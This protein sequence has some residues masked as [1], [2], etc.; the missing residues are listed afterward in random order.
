MSRTSSRTRTVLAGTLAGLLTVSG[1]AI[2]AETIVSTTTTEPSRQ[3]EVLDL[4]GA[5]LTELKLRHGIPRPFEV[6][7]TDVD[8]D[9]G[10]SFSVDATMNNLHL[11]D[12]SDWSGDHIASEHVDLS[13]STNPLAAAGLEVD[14]S[15][16]LLLSTV[17]SVSCSAVAT[18]RGLSL[19]SLTALLTDPLCS[20]LADLHGINLLSLNA[21]TN[22][23][24]A[25][26]AFDDVAIVGAILD[27]IDL[28]G[29]ALAA[30]PLVPGHGTPGS[31]D[32]P[33]CATGIGAPFCSATTPTVRQTLRGDSAGVLS[34]SLAD[35]LD[36]ALGEL[37]LVSATGAGAV[38]S[39]DDV[40]AALLASS[41]PLTDGGGNPLGSTVA[42][43]GQAL[44]SYSTANQLAIIDSLLAS[45]LAQLDLD[46]LLHLTG[47]Y[48]SY[49]AL[50]VD[51]TT[52][53]V[54][55]EYQG[56]LTVTLVE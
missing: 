35:L 36:A 47:R 6:R 34:T 43:F 55:G 30:L 8:Q 33:E 28:D 2:A 3:L 31:F 13:F 38:A 40:L 54:G 4:S 42:Q 27:A 22:L 26:L 41:E 45:T 16:E 23:L 18:L 25:D 14:L 51:T 1:L 17:D 48:S 7:V 50:A 19:S 15:P 12:G 39:I 21:L 56:T 24:A 10:R 29:L 5:P 32:V 53:P 20:L 11:F 37:D 9:P 44:A 46:A 52:A 49:P